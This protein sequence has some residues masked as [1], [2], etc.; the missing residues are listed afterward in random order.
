MRTL[1]FFCAFLTLQNGALAQTE[2]SVLHVS[3]QMQYFANQASKPVNLYP[4]MLLNIGGKIR[5]KGASSVK[6]VYE[7]MPIVVSGTKMRDLEEVVK[8]AAQTSQMSFTGRF[9]NFLN[10]SVKEGVTDEKL[11][12]H[13]RRY[14]T[15]SSGGI[16]GWAKADYAIRPLL[17]T[18]GKLPKANVIFKWRNT[19]GEG[20]Y[21]FHLLNEQNAWVAQLIVRDTCI[22]L[23]LDQL[24][25]NLDEEYHWSVERGESK[26]SVAIPFELCPTHPESIALSHEPAYQ[27]AGPAERAYMELFWLEEERYFYSAYQAYRDLME[28]E[29][30][31]PLLQRMYATFLARLDMLPEAETFL[32]L[33]NKH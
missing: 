28:A 1:I 32:A 11:K 23:D 31:N 14:M 6:L 20:P 22:T 10:E 13:H 26:K 29:P 33:N 12:K 2:I 18:T 30:H 5:G 27:A 3:G 7:G 17:I 19:P 4:G 16:K 21:T 24:A 9:F 8:T 25:L 15:K